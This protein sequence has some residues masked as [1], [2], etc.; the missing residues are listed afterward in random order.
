MCLG[1]RKQRVSAVQEAGL[2]SRELGTCPPSGHGRPPASAQ[3]G[4]ESWRERGAG[5]IR[6]CTMATGS[7]RTLA[8]VASG[9]QLP[10][11]Q[12]C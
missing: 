4:A 1:F 6:I 3:D 11:D 10:V 12:G 7:T 8:Y 2:R 5:L 9:K